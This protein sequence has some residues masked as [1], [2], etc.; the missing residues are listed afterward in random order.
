M[1]AIRKGLPGGPGVPGTRADDGFLRAVGSAGLPDVRP[2]NP[3]TFGLGPTRAKAAHIVY[4][5][6][7]P[8]AQYPAL[9]LAIPAGDSDTVRQYG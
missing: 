2:K 8:N 9:R 4:T 3:W 5:G 1:R 7:P 6:G